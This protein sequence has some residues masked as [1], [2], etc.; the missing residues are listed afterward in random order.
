M[1][2]LVRFCIKNLASIWMNYITKSCVVRPPERW[3][4]AVTEFK[5]VNGVKI[6]GK[7]YIEREV[8][9]QGSSNDGR[10]SVIGELM[11]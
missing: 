3:R 9:M 11:R 2:I 4:H 8:R 10:Q 5:R 6:A 1:K 7:G